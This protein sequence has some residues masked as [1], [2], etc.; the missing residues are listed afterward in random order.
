MDVTKGDDRS[1]ALTL[2]KH[3]DLLLGAGD[4]SLAELSSLGITHLNLILL[5]DIPIKLI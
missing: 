1:G 5:L 2:R 3:K 4:D